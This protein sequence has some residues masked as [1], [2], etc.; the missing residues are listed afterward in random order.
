MNRELD[1]TEKIAA[2]VTMVG[3]SAFFLIWIV[4]IVLFMIFP[5]VAFFASL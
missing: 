1:K 3:V 2:G 5:G 4:P